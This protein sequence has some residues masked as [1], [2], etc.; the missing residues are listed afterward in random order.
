M[1]RTATGRRL[2]RDGV[3][4]ARPR[5]S[6]ES[7]DRITLATGAFPVDRRIETSLIFRHHILDRIDKGAREFGF[8]ILSLWGGHPGSLNSSMPR[9]G[10]KFSLAWYWSKPGGVGNEISFRDGESEPAWVGSYR[11]LNLVSD[12]QY[13]VVIE[14][15]QR[16]DSQGQVY[17]EQRLKWWQANEEIPAVWLV[18]EDREGAR[19]PAGEYANRTARI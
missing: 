5:P 11:G 10:W 6:R 7:Y 19:L 2:Q 4:V 15:R 17:I 18:T 13:R 16:D 1:C 14:V 3:A 12:V 8:G 9:R